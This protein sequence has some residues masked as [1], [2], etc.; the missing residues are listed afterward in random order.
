M[1][2]AVLVVG[3]GT[4]GRVL[5]LMVGSSGLILLRLGVGAGVVVSLVL[6]SR[7]ALLLLAPLLLSITPLE[8]FDLEAVSVFCSLAALATPNALATLAVCV[9]SAFFCNEDK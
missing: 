8:L 9:R 2:G 6:S 3:P 7:L 4:G 1:L 5:L